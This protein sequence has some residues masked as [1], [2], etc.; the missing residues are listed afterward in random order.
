M[1]GEYVYGNS[2]AAYAN[3]IWINDTDCLNRL[4]AYMKAFAVHGFDVVEYKDDLS[5]RIKYEQKLNAG[6]KKLAV[7]NSGKNYI[8]YDILNRFAVYTASLHRL[9]PKLN[10]DAL[11]HKSPM[12]LDLLTMVISK[13]F[14]NLTNK[15]Q[16][17][18]FFET[19]VFSKENL[20][21]Y[22]Q[23]K[24]KQ[25]FQLAT[26]NPSYKDWYR[27]AEEKAQIDRYSVQY[28]LD[29]NTSEINDL[30]QSYVLKAFGT[31]SSKIDRNTPVLVSHAMEYMHEQSGKFA[32]IVMDGMS[33]FDWNIISQ[34]FSD[35]AYEQTAAFAMIPS[36]TSISRQCLLSNKFPSQLIAP[37]VQSKERAEFTECAK[38]LGYADSQIGYARGYDTDFSSSV[39]C[40]AVII[41]DVDDMVHAQS[42]GRL[43]MYNDIS[44]LSE[45]GKLCHLTDRLLSKGFDVYITADHGNTLCNGI[46]R[47]VGAGVDVETKSHRMVV[48]KDFADKAKMA[49]KFGLIEYPKYYL[50]KEYDYLIC[51]TDTSLDNLGEQVMTHGGMTIDEV[52]VPFIKIK[53]VQNNG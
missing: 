43:G 1:F 7:L 34:S 17:E 36:T 52:V 49:D 27:I 51:N 25:I 41:N 16:T 28:G 45:E 53:A 14:D 19:V 31:L 2:P 46:G 48:L 29:I 4:T 38:A 5:F 6:E 21:S 50:P 13:N 12:D 9:F 35:I 24:L 44:V 11:R 23:S 20:S 3:F 47:F 18:K 22:F 40:G 15:E 10:T 26:G 32:I 37:W 30:F 42:Q 33:E 39:R 8:P